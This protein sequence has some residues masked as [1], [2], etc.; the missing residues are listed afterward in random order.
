M[1]DATPYL[2]KLTNQRK[3]FEKWDI[4]E[5]YLELIDERIAIE[6]EKSQKRKDDYQVEMSCAPSAERIS[7]DICPL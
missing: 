1:N 4:A 7:K 6:N 2:H 5:E 3:R